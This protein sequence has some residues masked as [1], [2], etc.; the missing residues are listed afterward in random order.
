MKTYYISTDSLSDVMATLYEECAAVGATF[1]TRPIENEILVK[2][3]DKT[4]RIKVLEVVDAYD[5]SREIFA[6]K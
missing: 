1:E 4:V 3:S 5:I 6:K 2:F